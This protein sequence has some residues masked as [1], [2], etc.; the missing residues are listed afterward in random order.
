LVSAKE[1]AMETARAMDLE[2]LVPEAQQDP[3]RLKR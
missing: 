2:K 1:K 3:E